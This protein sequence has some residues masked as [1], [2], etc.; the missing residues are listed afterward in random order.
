MSKRLAC[1]TL[2][3]AL[4]ASAQKDGIVVIE[5][6]MIRYAGPAASAPPPRPGDEMLDYSRF[7][8]MPGLIDVHTHLSYGNAKTEEDIDLYGAL[9]FRA[10]RGVFFAQQVLAAG[11]T[12]LCVP[13]DAGHVSTSIRDAI[14]A[15][16]F[17]GPR[18]TTA[19]PYL[20]NRQGLT[21]WYPTWIG[22]PETA[23]SRVV[24]SSVEAIEEIRR[25]V[26]DGVDCIKIA[27]D[28]RDIRPNGELVAAFT[29]EE[30]DVMV[31]EAHRLGRKVVVHARGR[32]AVL[33]S[34]K[35]SADLIFHASWMDK[36]GLEWVV[37]NG[38]AISPTLT[39]MR[40]SIDFTQDIDPSGKRGRR[41]SATHEFEIACKALRLAREA[42]V[43][44]MTGT[45]SGFA[46]T[47]YGEWHAREIGI[48]VRY[49]GFSPAQ[50]LQCA[51]A[52]SAQ[53]LRDGDRLGALQPGRHADLVVVDGDPLQDVSLLL[54]RE[55]LH[56][57][58]LAG[59]K[60]ELKRRSYNPRKVSD[61]AYTWW[62][63]LY[64]QQRVE[65]L[66][67]GGDFAQAG[68]HS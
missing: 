24:R 27:M 46:I 59:E 50:A 49:L 8:V 68:K 10:I 23:N 35:A 57:I 60:V 33:Y 14:D 25:Q 39:Y 16:L 43:P 64:T 30:T 2:F 62:N 55:R 61:F 54:K 18:V 41:E 40:H 34:A 1:G 51:T 42:G 22:V 20:T 36:E 21:D 12:S 53:F 15:G 52:T 63:D 19:G 9:E 29:Q 44:M 5:D 66:G 32:E 67:L 65:E 6:G 3:D 58:Y 28:G 4:S 7:F 47:P 38:C 45:D 31:R 37:K 13:G 48:F 56:A 26:K 17:P 11:Y